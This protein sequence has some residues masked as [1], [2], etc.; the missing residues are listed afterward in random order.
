VR[1]IGADPARLRVLNN[2]VDP[3][4]YHPGPVS[5]AV[6]ERLRALNAAPVRLSPRSRGAAGA[7][8]T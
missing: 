3:G 8:T 4:R 7:E 5:S 1:R 2:S 6:A